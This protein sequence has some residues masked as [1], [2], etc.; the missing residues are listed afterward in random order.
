MKK[1]NEKNLT[2]KDIIINSVLT[3]LAKPVPVKLQ[4]LLSAFDEGERAMVPSGF[5]WVNVA[6]VEEAAQK[7]LEFVHDTGCGARDWFGGIVR[8]VNKTPV[9][10]VNI[11]GQIGTVEE[12]GAFL[13][14]AKRLLK[15]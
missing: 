10:V 5:Q 14:N 12:N 1:Q 11:R 7:V 9:A 6:S 2:E 8:D 13:I 15:K 4:V 3:Q